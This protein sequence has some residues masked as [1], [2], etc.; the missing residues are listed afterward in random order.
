MFCLFSKPDELQILD[1]SLPGFLTELLIPMLPLVPT[2]A[3]W[4]GPKGTEPTGAENS[5][6]AEVF[7]LRL[8]MKSQKDQ[9]HPT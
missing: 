9:H 7:S 1:S 4:R 6:K 3:I 8:L 5:V 2:E